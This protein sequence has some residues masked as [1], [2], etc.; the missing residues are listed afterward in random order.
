[1]NIYDQN[2]ATTRFKRDGKTSTPDSTQYVKD[3]DEN[4]KQQFDVWYR[5]LFCDQWREPTSAKLNRIATYL[6]NFTS[7]TYMMLN[8]R[9]GISN[10]TTGLTNI[11]AEAFAADYFGHRDWANGTG[12]Y[13]SGI[14]DYLKNMFTNKSDTLEGGLIKYFH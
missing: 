13:Y 10:L 4:L 7:S 3:N 14:T 11:A 12:H 5:R 8:V 2:S 6:Q 1:A 9:G